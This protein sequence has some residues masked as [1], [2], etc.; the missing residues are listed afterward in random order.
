MSWAE[1]RPRGSAGDSV[2]SFDFEGLLNLITFGFWGVSPG[3]GADPNKSE[4][5]KK[6]LEATDRAPRSNLSW[7]VCVFFFF[8]CFL[9]DICFEVRKKM[10]RNPPPPLWICCPFLGGGPLCL[11]L[12]GLGAFLLS[13]SA[14]RSLK[15]PFWKW[16]C[17]SKSLIRALYV[18]LYLHMQ[19]WQRLCLS[20]FSRVETRFNTHY[21][22]VYANAFWNA[23]LELLRLSSNSYREYEV[24]R[25]ALSLRSCIA[26]FDP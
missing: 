7:A 17:P 6:P 8:F 18:C 16:P 12:D 26:Q 4:C 13:Q 21:Q 5:N 3:A 9:G 24:E 1:L 25:K 14:L 22:N 2:C 23:F 15:Y 10:C 19:N 11:F 20:S